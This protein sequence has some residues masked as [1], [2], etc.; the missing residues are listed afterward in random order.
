MPNF[1]F[2][3]SKTARDKYKIE[4]SLFS[5]SGDL[6]IANFKQARILANKINNVRKESGQKQNFTSAGQINALGLIHEIFH[7]LIRIYEEKVNPGVFI[8]A[9]QN[10]TSSLGE[11]AVERI[12]SEYISEFPPS[13]V[14]KGKISVLDYLSG[15][16]DN[17]S[18]REIILEELILLNLENNNP[19][20]LQLEELYSDET[21]AE[22]TKYPG[23]IDRLTNFFSSQKPFGPES[24][25]L[26]EFLKKPII[27]SPYSLEGQLEFIRRNWGVYVYDK[28]NYRLLGGRDLIIEDLKLFI[29][30]GFGPKPTPPV[31]QYKYDEDYLRRIREKLARGNELT[32]DEQDY[33]NSEIERFTKDIEWMPKVVMLAKNAYVWMDQLSKKYNRPINRL[34]EIPDEELNRLASWNFT[35]LWLIGIWERSSASRKIKQ[36]TGNPEAAA[37]AYSL[38]DYT[39]AYELGG[40]EAFENLKTRAWQRGIRLASDMVPNHTG[41]YSKWVIEKPDYFI[42]SDY[43]PFPGYTFN[44]PNLSDDPRV[45]VRIEDK[46]YSREDASVVFQRRDSFTGSIKYIYHGNDGTH[47]PWNDTAQL[48][49]LNPEVRE[50]LIQMIMHVARKTPI[51]RFDAAMT[52]SKKHYQR[53]WFPQ[54]G[55]GGA[56][57][58]RSDYAM[59]KESFNQAMSE[60]FWREVVDRMNA[61]MPETLLLAEAFWLMEGYFVRSLGMH[62]VYNSA[63]MHMLMKEENDKYREL[64]KNTLDFNPEILKRYVNFMSNPDEETAVNQFGKGDKYFGVAVLM[65]TLPGMPMFG[66]GQVEGLSEKYGMEYKRAYYDE[67]SDENLI[68]RHEYEIFPLIRKRY[69]FSQVDE[70]ELYDFID[71]YNNVNENVFAYSNKSGDEKAFIVYNN[72]YEQA[73]GHINF[74]VLKVQKSSEK[75]SR[76]ITEA[77]NLNNKWGH[78]YT[79]REHK[80]KLQYLV[81]GS[82]IDDNGMYFTLNGYEYK[83]LTDFKEIYDTTG[84]FETLYQTIRG[85]GVPSIEEKLKEMKLAPIHET[86]SYLLD[87]NNLTEITKL[88]FAESGISPERADNGDFELPQL[89]RDRLTGFMN[90]VAELKKIPLDP[91][92]ALATTKQLMKL[93]RTF[94]NSFNNLKTKKTAQKKLELIEDSIMTSGKNNQEEKQ[95]LISFYFIYGIFNSLVYNTKLNWSDLYDSLQINKALIEIFKDL[96]HNVENIYNEAYLV[97]ALI[98]K[99]YL[100]TEPEILNPDNVSTFIAELINNKEVARY[101]SLNE[102]EGILYYNKE[103]FE[104]LL[105]WIFTALSIFYSK[106]FDDQNKKSQSVKNK[107]AAQT[108]PKTSISQYE[109]ALIKQLAENYDVIELLKLKSAEAGYRLVNLKELLYAGKNV[110]TAAPHKNN[111]LKKKQT[112]VKK[113]TSKKKNN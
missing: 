61:E 25:S 91:E 20:A 17:K 57:P 111:D 75:K 51:I 86:L 53:L 55:T 72:S 56:I 102:F 85:T 67:H 52:L 97:K 93:T 21:I 37:S 24:Q 27:S 29:H 62:R 66:H 71:K 92:N 8:N 68:R 77:F 41:I 101:I 112:S 109:K 74:S 110:I 98:S 84:E 13:E 104:N 22:K 44:G 113:K 105:N 9:L 94:Q 78:F 87:K 36:L 90:Q 99:A 35:A 103:N 28:F 7:Y 48:N 65:V 40:E 60:E 42:Q 11:E 50:A 80:T 58:S 70:F 31:P 100:F 49:L 32:A 64:I 3:V 69:L 79:F 2:H 46:Y 34:D 5:I 30:Q 107:K 83:V 95:L 59:T 54:P 14:Y 26:I 108:V 76:K 23:L 38:F 4:H 16:S 63:F 12:F 45:E 47:M 1:E 18:N 43:P 82:E 88:T 106:V 6:I 33:Y 73:K 39:I 89:V 96:G 19:A 10:M 15:Y 81:S